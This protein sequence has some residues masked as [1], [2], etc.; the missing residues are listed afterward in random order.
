MAK[1]LRKLPE[2]LQ[3][4]NKHF[5]VLILLVCILAAFTGIAKAYE[6]IYT[7][8]MVKDGGEAVYYK[9]T[10]ESVGEFLVEQEIVLEELD[11]INVAIDDEIKENMHIVITRAFDVNISVD[12]GK[13]TAV[14]TNETTVGKVIANLRKETGLDYILEDGFSS[15]FKTEPDMTINL[16]SV[17]EEITSRTE[18]IPFETETVENNQLEEGVQNVVTEGVNGEKE[19][20]IK[21]VYVGGKPSSAEESESIVVKEPVNKVIEIGTKPKPEAKPVVKT[22]NGSYEIQK[23]LYVQTTA[24]TASTACTGKAPGSK[25]FGVTAS[26]MKAAVGVVAVDPNVIP[27]GTKLYIEGYGYAV[28][29]DTGGTIKN[30]KIDLYFNTNAE[31]IKYGVKNNVKVYVLGQKVA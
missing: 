5:K 9:T 2:H 18:A 10:A 21:T 25:G 20:K 30:N 14:R 13:A 16:K 19:I 26:G 6:I 24:Y 23:E 27:L 31:C 4:I 11:L 22:N 17:K 7:G 12:G 3:G 28:A 29:G 15:S 1:Q 8:V